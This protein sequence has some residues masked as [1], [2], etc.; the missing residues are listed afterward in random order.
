MDLLV[1]EDPAIVTWW[2]TTVECTSAV[3]RLEGDGIL[4][5]GDV[6]AAM[7][8]LR[9]ASQT[10]IEVPATTDVR[11]QAIRLLRVHRL[12]ATDALQLAAAIVASDFQASAI[13]FVTLD[14]RQAA[15]AEREGF[16]LS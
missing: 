9:V 11:E 16:T 15:A 5:G 6:R 10:W 2:G 14:E 8:R 3:A 4:A 7:E 12:R 1:Q 13:E